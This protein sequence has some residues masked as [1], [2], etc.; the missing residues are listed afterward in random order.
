[1][2]CALALALGRRTD[3]VLPVGWRA[4]EPVWARWTAGRVDPYRDD[5][6]SWLDSSITAAQVGQVVGQFLD[7]WT[8]LLRRDTL[9]YAVSYYVQA[10][11]LDPERGTAAAIS[12]LLLLGRSWLVEDRRVYTSGEWGQMRDAG[13]GEA[14]TQI[15]ALLQFR[16]AV[17]VARCPE[18]SPTCKPLPTGSTRTGHRTSQS[19]MALAA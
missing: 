12:G 9:R 4:D 16:N 15:R 11:A 5:R 18:I 2:R 17:S 10:L 14:E 7:N 8:D 1:M 13:G 19:A 3:V 6:G